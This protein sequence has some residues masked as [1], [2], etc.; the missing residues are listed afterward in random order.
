MAGGGT[1]VGADGNFGPLAWATS[2]AND[3]NPASELMQL[4]L[5]ESLADEMDDPVWRE[6]NEQITEQ[7]VLRANYGAD[8]FEQNRRAGYGAQTAAQ[9]GALQMS[10]RY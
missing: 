5:I 10:G 9:M 4:N 8:R 2:L 1:R 3:P 7:V 6:I